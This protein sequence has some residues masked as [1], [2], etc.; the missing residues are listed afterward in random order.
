MRLGDVQQVYG[1]SLDAA[2]LL[3]QNLS[4]SEM[5]AREAR[6][7]G[8]AEAEERAA[9]VAAAEEGSES[10]A[11]ALRTDEG[12]RQEKLRRYRLAWRGKGLEVELEIP[13][14]MGRGLDIEA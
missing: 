9:Q 1:K 8:M 3:A 5:A 13:R 7:R 2:A 10:Q 6:R 4:A 11:A 14:P 12:A